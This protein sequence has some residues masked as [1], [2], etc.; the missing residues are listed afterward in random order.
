MVLAHHRRSLLHESQDVAARTAPAV[1]PV[2]T[3][4][5]ENMTIRQP[6]PPA[7]QILLRVLARAQNEQMG[8]AQ[9]LQEKGRRGMGVL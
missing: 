8:A 6:P 1:M 2:Y 9:G 5:H 4:V 3:K 7:Q